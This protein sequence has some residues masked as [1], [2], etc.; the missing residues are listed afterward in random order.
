MVRT[1]HT[2][3][4]DPTPVCTW[5][6]LRRRRKEEKKKKMEKEKREGRERE[7]EERERERDLW[8]SLNRRS[9]RVHMIKMHFIH[10]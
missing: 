1:S 6:A 4:D 7:R 8:S 3:M 10:I 2:A 5:K 9:E